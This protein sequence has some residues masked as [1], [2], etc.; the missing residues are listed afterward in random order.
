MINPAKTGDRRD[1]AGEATPRRGARSRDVYKSVIGDAIYWRKE[2]GLLTS[3]DAAPKPDIAD[4]RVMR[5]I[6]VDSVKDIPG[7]SIIDLTAQ[8]C[9]SGTC[10]FSANGDSL[11]YDAHHLAVLGARTV[12][13]SEVDVVRSRQ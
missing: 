10:R 8:F 6:I 7:V 12:D 1:H 3:A 13:W 4:L 9:S 5:R 11:Y 2:I